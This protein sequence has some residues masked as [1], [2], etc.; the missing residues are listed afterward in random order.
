MNQISNEKFG[1]FLNEMRKEKNLTQKQLAE[2]LFVSDKTVSKWECG[3]SMPNVALLIPIADA[4]DI[5]VT[6]LLK[7]ERIDLDKGLDTEEVENLAVG[8]VDLSVRNTMLQR[9]TYWIISYLIC[10]FITIGE[11][12]ALTVTGLTLK[13]MQSSILLVCGMTIVF[14]GWLCFFAKQV[15]PG[16][17]DSNKINYYSQGIF[18]VHMAGL[19]FNNENWTYIC[20]V[21]KVGLMLISVLYPLIC[22]GVLMGGGA[23]LWDSIKMAVFFIMMLFLVGTIYAVGKKYE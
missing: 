20:A 4:L 11:I 13:Q 22:Y 18:R 16:Y 7:G 8:L 19:S 21:C 5:T 14:N 17:Y 2:K 12:G 1:T 3:G 10:S 23:A 6:E 15:L 9:K